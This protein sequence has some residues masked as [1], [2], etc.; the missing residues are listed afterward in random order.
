M[1]K[2]NRFGKLHE[3]PILKT[4]IFLKKPP[5]LELL[6]LPEAIP[7]NT[8]HQKPP[9]T[10]PFKSAGVKIYLHFKYC[11][12]PYIFTYSCCLLGITS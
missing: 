9:P 10:P 12:L 2:Q 4:F 11:V 8:K 1:A 5:V 6:F 3:I 7:L